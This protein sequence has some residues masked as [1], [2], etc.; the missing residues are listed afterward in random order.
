MRNSHKERHG[1]GLVRQDGGSAG[2]HD[3]GKAKTRPFDS[4]ARKDVR[5]R[6][7]AS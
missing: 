4:P 7:L 3:A 2:R 1:K 6:A 5:A